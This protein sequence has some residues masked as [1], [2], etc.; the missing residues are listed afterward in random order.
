MSDLLICLGDGHSG[1]W[2]IFASI[3]DSEKRCEILDW[4]HLV[5]NLGKVGGSVKRLN[6]VESLL[7]K[8]NVD[9]AIQQ[10]AD[11]KHEKVSNFV[12][13]LN[14][15]RH[16]IVNYDYYQ[17]EGISI[18]SGTIEST[19]KQIGRRVKISGS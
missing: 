12:S 18:G 15:H 1:I 16:R 9:E 3:A 8:G 5:E 11:W 6:F 7:W 13:Y 2:N 19:I 14:K 17:A 10:F 4:Y